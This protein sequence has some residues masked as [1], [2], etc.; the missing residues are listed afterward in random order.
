MLPKGRDTVR[1]SI[2]GYISNKYLMFLLFL[3]VLSVLIPTLINPT[4]FG[5]DTYT[6]QYQTSSIANSYSM[7]EYYTSQKNEGSVSYDYPFGLWLIGSIVQKICG[8]DIHFIGKYFALILLGLTLPIFYA[9]SS[10]FLTGYNQKI[11]ALVFLISMPL[12]NR[13]ITFVSSTLGI[14]FLTTIFYLLFNDSSKGLKHNFLLL[15]FGILLCITHVGT[16]MFLVIFLLAYFLASSL[17]NG[18]IEKKFFMA[19]IITLVAY[20]IS[21]TLFTEIRPQ[22]IDKT[23][24]FL[25]PG[26]ILH[27]LNLPF[28]DITPLI[29]EMVFKET[30]IAFYFAFFG[31]IYFFG[32]FFAQIHQLMTT[33]KNRFHTKNA[34][35]FPLLGG[36]TN[37]S[38]SVATAPIWLGPT[39]TFL[40]LFSI[41]KLDRPGKLLFLVVA[42]ITILSGVESSEAAGATGAVRK[43]FYLIIILPIAASLGLYQINE[44][45]VNRNFLLTKFLFIIFILGTLSSLI[46]M[47]VVQ[48]T[49]FQVSISGEKYEKEGLIWLSN[50]GRPSDGIVGNNYRHFLSV[51]ADK[52]SPGST[53]IS[54]GS[55]TRRFF[56]DREAVYLKADNEIEIFDL[57]ASWNVKYYV[58]SPRIFK[59]EEELFEQLTINENTMID[60]IFSNNKNKF[61]L[62]TNNEDQEISIGNWDPDFSINEKKNFEI[63]DSGNEFLAFTDNYAIRVGKSSPVI[64]YFGTPQK[65]YIGDGIIRAFLLVYDNK[66]FRKTYQFQDGNFSVSLGNSIISYDKKLYGDDNSLIGDLKINY[67]FFNKAVKQEILFKPYSDYNSLFIWRYILPS[68]Y[69]ILQNEEEEQT[70]RNIYPSVD[71]IE[72]ENIKFNRIYINS[73]KENGIYIQ[74]TDSFPYPNSYLYKGAIPPHLNSIIGFTREKKVR[75]GEIAKLEQFIVVDRDFEE[76]RSIIKDYG[77]VQLYPFPKAI[78][79]LIKYDWDYPYD[80]VFLKT[81]KKYANSSKYFSGIYVKPPYRLN[82]L[83]GERGITL[84]NNDDSVLF[85]LCL[86]EIDTLTPSNK[87]DVFQM[88]RAHLSSLMIHENDMCVFNWKDEIFQSPEFI[89]EF[90]EFENFSISKGF[91]FASPE[92]IGSHFLLLNKV[93]VKV[94][95]SEKGIKIN[96]D[97]ENSEQI[98]GLTFRVNPNPGKKYLIKGINNAKLEREKIIGNDKIIYIS[99]NVPAN[100]QKEVIIYIK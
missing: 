98:T 35:V 65:D 6:H 53:S 36:I 37:I 75:A 33:V 23:R 92:E 61:G 68:D 49:Y 52:F 10:R 69:F 48:N 7:E 28:L 15:I 22:Y 72:V 14:L 9:F 99:T 5:T 88:W 31:L 39:Q 95:Q 94:Y 85:P 3:I 8:V 56:S 2:K 38:H 64:N 12:A 74:M 45:F 70:F 83:E 71:P 91:T 55:E 11:M 19:I 50:Y 80:K 26:K 66:N 76:S 93:F 30:K 100:S 17:I 29:Y 97:N 67:V 27:F 86:P 47:P 81:D 44:Y 4:P 63:L 73:T 79:P 41:K 1:D 54:H 77:R 59:K 82:Y 40:S 42:A 46:L 13:E 20:Y 87:E 32:I 51:Y 24:I 60:K 78:K 62:Y 18:K 96:I 43:I 21:T 25:T 84:F 57:L 90:Q 16:F 89:T 58:L 34:V